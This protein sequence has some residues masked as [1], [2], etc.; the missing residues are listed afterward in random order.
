MRQRMS[1]QEYQ[2]IKK[3]K[4]SKYGNK[5]TTLDG[6]VFDSKAEAKYYE[7]LKWLQECKEILFFRTQPRYLL[8]EAFEK[9]GKTHRKIEYVADFEVHQKDESI[10]VIDVKG[11]E[12]D[13][14]K[15]KEKMFHIKYPHKLSVVT[16]DP[17]F[18]WIELDK[19]KELKRLKE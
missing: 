11:V 1:V 14:F 16:L 12:T 10:E 9:D 4:R 8:Q 15:M 18:G 13:V 6:I 19:L 7:Q 5:K 17:V 3:P 2:N